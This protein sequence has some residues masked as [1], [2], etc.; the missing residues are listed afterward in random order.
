MNLFL[1]AC[2][3]SDKEKLRSLATEKCLRISGETYQKRYYILYKNIFSARQHLR[4]RWGVQLFAGNYSQGIRYT[5]SDWLCLCKESREKESHL[6]L[7]ECIEYGDLTLNSND[8]NLVNMLA[9]R[10]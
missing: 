4:S 1:K 6:L 5:K 2:R 3:K 7:G 9:R 10:E 8:N